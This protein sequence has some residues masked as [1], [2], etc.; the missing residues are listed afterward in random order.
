[1]RGLTGAGTPGT[2]TG[3]TRVGHAVEEAGYKREVFGKDIVVGAFWILRGDAETTGARV[4][5]AGAGDVFKIFDKD[6]VVGAAG[7]SVGTRSGA[8]LEA[9]TRSHRCDGAGGIGRVAMAPFSVNRVTVGGPAQEGKDRLIA[10]EAGEKGDGNAVVVVGPRRLDMAVVG[11][12]TEREGITFCLVRPAGGAVVLPGLGGAGVEDDA[13]EGDTKGLAQ[14]GN[15]PDGRSGGDGDCV[16][17]LLG[18][19]VVWVVAVRKATCGVI[20][21]AVG[22][23]DPF[24]ALNGDGDRGGAGC[25]LVGGDEFDDAFL[26]N[27]VV[28]VRE[29]GEGEKQGEVELVAEEVTEGGDG[30]HSLHGGFESAD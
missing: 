16:A 17:V 18:G 10:G 14:E 27:G 5:I 3:K 4:E 23:D 12:K 7:L 8:F 15:G 9:V 2:T 19:D 29:G 11:I 6:A 20:R 21:E 30:Y 24:I 13:V 1:M 22:D 25:W 26:G 28:R